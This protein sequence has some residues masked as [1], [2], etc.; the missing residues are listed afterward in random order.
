MG[1][2]VRV[3]VMIKGTPGVSVRAITRAMVRIR[4]MVMVR[5]SLRVVATPGE[6]SRCSWLVVRL[7]KDHSHP[8]HLV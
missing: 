1:A 2:T 7:V 8:K 3:A 4:V 5:V 6:V